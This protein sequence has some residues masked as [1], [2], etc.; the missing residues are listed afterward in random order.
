MSNLRWKLVT[1]LLVFVVFFGIGVYPILANRY[2]LPAPQWLRSQDG[3]LLG[4]LAFAAMHEAYHV[5]QMGFL[6]KWL[7]L[8]PIFDG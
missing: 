7:G 2:N 3:T 4:G 5:G 6:R 1:I 8:D